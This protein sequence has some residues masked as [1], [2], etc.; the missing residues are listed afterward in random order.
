MLKNGPLRALVDVAA[1]DRWTS[2]ELSDRVRL[3]HRSGLRFEL[4]PTD[5]PEW[6]PSAIRER[7]T[8]PYEGAM[9]LFCCSSIV[10][11]DGEPIVFKL[12][13]APKGTPLPAT[14][15]LRAEITRVFESVNILPI[16]R[17]RIVIDER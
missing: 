10:G 9:E 17:I 8:A 1:G 7:F 14:A 12:M 4:C 6:P 15:R 13:Y 2:E 3:T 11:P 5:M 16:D